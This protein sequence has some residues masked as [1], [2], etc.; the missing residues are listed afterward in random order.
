MVDPAT[1]AFSLENGGAQLRAI[2]G[3]VICVRPEATRQM[4]IRD[5]LIV[6]DYVAS[7]A[8]YYQAEVS[9]PWSMVVESVREETAR[10][11]EED[12]VFV[13]SGDVGAFVCEGWT[14]RR[15]T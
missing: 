5:A 4:L 15:R 3:H 2:F 12:G 8:D 10:I 6:A 9:C 13:T 11:I 7:T 14:A 1:R